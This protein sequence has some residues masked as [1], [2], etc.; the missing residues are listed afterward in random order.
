MRVMLATLD[1]S[2][3][4]FKSKVGN[5]L[6]KAAALSINLNIDDVPKTSLYLL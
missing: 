4:Q 1:L 5:I 3:S 6:A 2:Y